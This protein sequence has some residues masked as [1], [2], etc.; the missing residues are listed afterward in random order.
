MVDDD[1]VLGPGF[2]VRWATAS[3]TKTTSSQEP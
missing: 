3:T 1:Q 2:A